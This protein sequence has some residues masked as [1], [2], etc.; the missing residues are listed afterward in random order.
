MSLPPELE[1]IEFIEEIVD[2][3]GVGV[4]LYDETGRFLYVN[5]V[6]AALLDAERESLLGTAIWEINPEFDGERFDDYWASFDD[7]ETRV[8]ET[9]HEYEGTRV[10]VSASTTQ[11]RVNGTA[12]H[13]GTIRDIA[14]RKERERQLE[15]LHTVTRDLMEAGSRDEIAS[16]AA[17]TAATILDHEQTVARF[18][19]GDS[20]VP[21]AVSDRAAETMGERPTYR[22]DGETPAARA[23]RTGEPVR[24]DDT[25]DLDDGYDRPGMRSVMY[26]PI[27]DW[28]VLGVGSS[29]RAAFDQT[30]VHLASILGT[31]TETALDRLADE[32]DLE[33]QNERFEAFYEVISHDIPNHLSV[34]QT[35]L[36]LAVQKEAFDQLDHVSKAHRRIQTVID[37]MKTLVTQG[38]QVDETERVRLSTLVQSTWTSCR[39]EDGDATLAVERDGWVETDRTRLT[40]LFENLF[41]NALDHAGPD[42]T[43]WVGVT[44]RGFYVEDDGP[45]IPETAR[46]EVLVPGYTTADDHAG[47]GLA[48]V[49]GIVRAH[50]WTISVTEG[51]EGGAR[52]EVTGVPV[53]HER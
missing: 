28:G 21:M 35:R 12:Y 27:G 1:D 48:I 38:R 32:R 14:R 13:V 42:V 50:D 20:L 10:A 40:Q 43:I 39:P 23:Y 11:S 25:D 49:R 5:R 8:V 17:R 31:D 30:A 18:A 36:E 52:F 9:V 29:A 22:V 41:W 46:D 45:G 6:Y 47:F 33:R 16:I 2:T 7:G 44:D 37:D 51:R 24:I 4:A 19:E 53:D 34:A 15:Q 3:V 26:V